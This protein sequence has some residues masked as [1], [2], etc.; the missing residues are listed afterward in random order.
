MSLSSGS[1]SLMPY[2]LQQNLG[3][4]ELKNCSENDNE[5]AGLPKAPTPSS[6]VANSLPIGITL[7]ED[8]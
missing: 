3:T 2:S 1:G 4:R 6:C 7:W 8:R 5:G